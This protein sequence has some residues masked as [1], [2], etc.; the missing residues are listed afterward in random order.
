MKI[1]RETS[2]TYKGKKYFKYKVNLPE[3]LL[4]R[5]SMKIGDELQAE[6]KNYRIILSKR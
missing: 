1:L 2:R 5:A 6:V 4:E 3:E